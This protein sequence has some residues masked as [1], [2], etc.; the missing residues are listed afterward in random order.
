[1]TNYKETDSA[2]GTWGTIYITST[3]KVG[4]VTRTIEVGVRQ[5][6]FLSNLYL[7]N[8]NLVDPTM[9]AAWGQ[10]CL[11]TAQAASSMGGRSTP[12][13]QTA[14]GR[15]R[16]S[17]EMFNYWITGNVING[18]MQSNDDYYICG[19][20][21]FDDMV[22]SADPTAA[23]TPYWLDHAC[24]GARRSRMPDLRGDTWKF[25]RGC[26]SAR[27]K[28]VSFPSNVTFI[29]GYRWPVPTQISVAFTTARPRSLSEARRQQMEVY[30]PDTPSSNTNCLGA[31]PSTCP[32]PANGVIY[33]ANLPA[34]INCTV[35]VPGW[36][37][38]AGTGCLG[39]AFVAGTEDGQITVATDN[40]IYLVAPRPHSAAASG[41]V[42][43]G[44]WGC[45]WPGGR[46]VRPGQQRHQWRP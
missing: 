11:A 43:P 1:M 42:V 31:T 27:T 7:S 29:E 39:N 23:D 34:N 26:R 4:S 35:D 12:P 28:T 25:D 45:H 32:L 37:H 38:L 2:T 3:G 44:R 41:G 20:P 46:Q 21:Q 19:N 15:T 5:A 10:M 16:N 33:V 13:V 6:D 14:S 40:N 36:A 24:L 22:T 30:S 8:Y 9:D 17:C 18:P